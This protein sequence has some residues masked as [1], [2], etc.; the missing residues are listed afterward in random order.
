MPKWKVDSIQARS[1]FT[2]E[3]SV[4][5]AKKKWTVTLDDY[6]L[7]LANSAAEV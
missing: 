2:A 4:L 5:W 6:P 1:L 3:F 7:D